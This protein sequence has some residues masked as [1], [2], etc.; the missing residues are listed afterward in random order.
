MRSKCN[1]SLIYL[2]N[3]RGEY[4]MLHRVKKK[5]D[6]NH[7][8]WIGVGGG[9]EYGESPEECALRETLEET[10]L[11]LTD[12]RYRG[13][14]TFDW[15]GAEE[16]Q[17]MHLF[18]AS[19]WTGELAECNEGDLEWVPKEKVYDLPIWEGDEIFFRLLEEDRPFFSLKLSYSAEDVLLRAV[20]DGKE[21][22]V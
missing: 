19:A 14:V 8:K 20:L 15:A 9:F 11:T 3:S 17:H 13:I 2:E 1:S 21:L 6:I 16:T 5:N 10:G 7:D 4:L 18:T 22:P 12:Y